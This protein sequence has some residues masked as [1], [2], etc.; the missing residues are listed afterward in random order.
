MPPNKP[1]GYKHQFV[2]NK[3]RKY[4][5]IIAS[6]NQEGV[7]QDNYRV[8]NFVAYPLDINTIEIMFLTNLNGTGRGLMLIGVI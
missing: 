1:V 3:G 4:R 7:F 8:F 5:Q 6:L 2:H